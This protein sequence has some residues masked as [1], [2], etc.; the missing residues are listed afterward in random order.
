MSQLGGASQQRCAYAGLCLC[1]M[2]LTCLA[3]MQWTGI[4]SLQ[5]NI[6]NVYEKQ[7]GQA[8]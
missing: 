2:L 1:R 3:G 7:M 8:E 6:A 4:K 5:L